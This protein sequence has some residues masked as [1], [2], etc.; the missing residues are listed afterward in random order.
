MVDK[1]YY[2]SK[3]VNDQYE[4]KR[5]VLN[6]FSEFENFDNRFKKFFGPKKIKTAGVDVRR[7]CRIMIEILKGIQS[8]IQMTKQDYEGDYE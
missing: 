7:S 3:N 2:E 4:A 6:L 1:N 8:K 5:D